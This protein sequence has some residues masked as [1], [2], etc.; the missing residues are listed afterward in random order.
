M[1]NSSGAYFQEYFG[2]ALS[3]T[4][5]TSQEN[6]KTSLYWGLHTSKILDI[7]APNN[8]AITDFNPLVKN[9][10]KFL[11][12][13]ADVTFSGVAA[14]KFNNNKFT[15]AK[16]SFPKYHVKDINGTILDAFLEAAYIR[17]ADVD[18]AAYDP[19]THLIDMSHASIKAHF[20]FEDSNATAVAANAVTVGEQ[21]II[22]ATHA[23]LLTIGATENTVGH[24]FVATSQGANGN[25]SVKPYR[26]K[27]ATMAKLLAEDVTK[28]NKYSAMTKYTAPFY[29][30]F[31]GV[32]I[33]NRDDAFFTD[34][35]TSTD[36]GGHAGD[37]GYTSGLDGNDDATPMK[38]K[39]LSNNAIR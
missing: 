18:G 13:D 37:C 23:D 38:G 29:G 14:D 19:V 2:Q 7:N 33:L 30:G 31:D 11:S 8:S 39:E 10:T 26:V 27:R 16:V 35:A 12:A 22:A 20:N 6:V 36:V 28:F 5:K 17:N 25:G 32:N 34:R 21:Y 3:G 15:L 1:L 9:L 24:I 4:Q